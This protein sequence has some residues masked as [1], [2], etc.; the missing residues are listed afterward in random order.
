MPSAV[1]LVATVRALEPPR[2]RRPRARHREP[3][4]PLG[5]RAGRSALDAGRRDQRLPRPTPTQELEHGAQAR[6]RA[7]RARAAESTTASRAAA[8]APRRSRSRRR[9]GEAAVA[10]RAGLPLD[11]RSRR[12]STR[13]PRRSTAPTAST[14]CPRRRR[15]IE[16]LRGAGPRR[17]ADLH[18]EDAP[19]ALATTRS[20]ERADRL[21]G[22]RCAT[23]AP[24]TGAGWLSPSAATCRRC[25]ASGLA[26][27]RSTSTS[28]PTAASSVSSEGR[29][30]PVG[31]KRVT[32]GRAQ[33]RSK[34][35]RP[36]TTPSS[37]D[38]ST[39]RPPRRAGRRRSRLAGR[40]PTCSTTRRVRP[41]Q[42]PFAPGPHPRG[43]RGQRQGLSRPR[44]P[45]RGG[46]GR[47]RRTGPLRSF[48]RPAPPQ[49]PRRLDQRLGEH[50]HVREHR[51]EVRVARPA[52]DDVQVDVVDDPG[53]GGAAE[54]PADVVP[55]RPVLGREC[56]QPLAVSRW[57]SSASS[58]VSPPYS[59]RCRFGAISRCPEVY[60]NRFRSTSAR[61]PRWTT[62]DSSGAQ[63]TQPGSSSA[64][65]TYSSRQGAHRGFGTSA[66][67]G[68]ARSFGT[69]AQPS[70][71]IISEARRATPRAPAPS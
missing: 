67:P 53:A 54:V 62:R 69:H 38:D 41:C 24:Y 59:P 58:P 10:L 30:Q 34:D 36:V 45:M 47:V 26:L 57:I 43:A 31:S 32:R 21:H 66:G 51:H 40:S 19:V 17:P 61:S 39:R 49:P 52:R 55:L 60:G 20:S 11:S 16:R 44:A 18:G 64:C 23:C 25:R 37:C 27:P 71:G 33:L 65:S 6:A 63:K 29:A 35:A 14:S 9:G 46:R 4:A 2:R 68:R 56:L 48:L 15:T 7:R 50:L 8:R 5:D 12:R 22:H 13:S 28:M 3:R 70:P 42:A 1:V